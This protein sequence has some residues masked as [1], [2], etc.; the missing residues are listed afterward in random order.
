M[1]ASIYENYYKWIGSI[2][3]I[4]TSCHLQ[5]NYTIIANSAVEYVNKV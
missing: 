2:Y 4:Y 3:K 5:N 1:P